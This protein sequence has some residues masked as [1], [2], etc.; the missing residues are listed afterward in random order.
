MHVGGDYRQEGSETFTRHSRHCHRHLERGHGSTRVQHSD[1]IRVRNREAQ[2]EE[3]K[4]GGK[5]VGSQNEDR[6]F[7]Q[8]TNFPSLER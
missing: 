4:E 1:W 7:D 6:S 3:V 2:Q 5:E 8:L